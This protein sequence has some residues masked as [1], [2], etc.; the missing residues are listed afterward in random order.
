MA[1]N[2]PAGKAPSR[3]NQTDGRAKL[4]LNTPENYKSTT[5]D[6]HLDKTSGKLVG[7]RGR[8]RDSLPQALPNSTPPLRDE[9]DI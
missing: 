6:S 8:R 4:D 7:K 9:N 3:G 5:H 1:T 2:H